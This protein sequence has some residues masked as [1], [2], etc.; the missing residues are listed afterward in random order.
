LNMIKI[1]HPLDQLPVIIDEM[2]YSPRKGED[3]LAG[4]P[5]VIGI[6]YL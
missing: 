6:G 2:R 4:C 3:H 5:I 1:H